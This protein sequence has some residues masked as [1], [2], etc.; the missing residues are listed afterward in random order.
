MKKKINQVF[1]E[2]LKDLVIDKKLYDELHSF[3]IKWSQKDSDYIEFLGGNLTGVHPVRFSSLD[4]SKFFVDILNVDQTSLQYDLHQCD[5]IDKAMKVSSNVVYLT[6]YYLMHRFA[7]SK[8]PNELKKE[9]LEELYF[10]FAYRVITS[11]ISYYFKYS[12]NI[13]TAKVVY[14][15]LSNRFLIKRL[16]TWQKVFQYRTKDIMPGTGI[17]YFRVLTCNADNATRMIAD[18]QG[19]IRGYIKTI[20][21]VLIDVNAN[22][23]KIISSTMLEEDDDGVGIKNT[24]N[25]DIGLISYIR[26]VISRPN[27]FINDDLVY[28]IQ[29]LLPNLSPDKFVDTLK[30]ISE[31]PQVKPGDPDDFIEVSIVATLTYLRTKN[32][33]SDYNKH[34]Y[35]ILNLMKRYWSSSSVKDERIRYTKNY[36]YNVAGNATGLKTKWLLATISIGVLLYVFLR[37]LYRIK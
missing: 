4:E 3:R 1:E 26:S 10:I 25:I 9:A 32:I 5:G 20:Y 30:Y 36:L 37:S 18:L 27:D 15:K 11:L 24:I 23:E 7:T 35:E 6:I 13:S 28:L 14:E 2:H 8:L 29:G 34:T 31:N 17:H 22:N 21:L 12:V 19:K 33:T 16:G